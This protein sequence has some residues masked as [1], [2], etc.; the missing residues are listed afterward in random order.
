MQRQR[1]LLCVLIKRNWD[2][3]IAVKNVAKQLGIDQGCIQIAGIK[4]AKA[5][6]AQHLTI[7]GGVIDDVT[8]FNV[9]DIQI[10]P[11]GYVREALSTYYLL[12]N[13]FTIAIKN[14]QID[15]SNLQARVKQIVDEVSVVGG[16]PNF[17]GHQRFG[18]TRPITHLVGK[19][20]IKGEFEEAAMLYLAKPSCDEHPTARQARQELARNKRFQASPRTFSYSTTLRKNHAQPLS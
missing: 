16:M 8:S 17:F 19:A 20:L 18:T 1:F 10:R 3:F 12:G 6:T 13:S 11:I 4:D 15:E 5:V 2:T 7:E 14:V 9:K